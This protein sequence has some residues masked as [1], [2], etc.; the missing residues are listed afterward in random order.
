MTRSTVKLF[1]DISHSIGSRL[2]LLVATLGTVLLN[3]H[4]LG[5]SGLGEVAL[6]Q[7]GVLLVTGMAGFVAAGA[8]VY[9]RRSH[10]AADIRKAAYLWCVLSAFVASGGGVLLGIIPQEWLYAAA[11]LGL[12]QSLVVFHSQLLIASGKIRANNHLQIVQ[13]SF[14][15]LTVSLAYFLFEF[16]TPTGFMWALSIALGISLIFSLVSLRGNWGEAPTSGIADKNSAT[17]LLFRYGSQ[18]STG[19]ILQLLTNRANLSLLDHF[20]GSA[21]AGVYSVVYYGVEAVWTI[22]RALA[23][24]VNTEVAAAAS[25]LERHSITISYLRR[26]LLMTLPLALLSALVPESIYAL[27]FG[28]DGIA[29][30]LRILVPGMLAGATSSIIAHHMSAIGLH[31]WNARTSAL[32]LVTLIIIGWNTIPEYG[33]LGAAFAASSAYCVQA[34]GLIAVWLKANRGETSPPQDA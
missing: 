34:L 5:E 1:S 8:V 21:G 28:I 4:F 17:P 3:S 33:V 11:G 31:K 22:A 27:I 16:T 7:F 6:L 25:H 18:G 14:L 26:T 19:S 9:V 12:I 32:G 24:M 10:R 15:L 20:I 30:P 23:P 13:T 2:L 29:L